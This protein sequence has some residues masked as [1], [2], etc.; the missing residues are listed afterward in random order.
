M[1]VVGSIQTAVL[2]NKS[3][4]WWLSRSCRG[5]NHMWENCSKTWGVLNR[6]NIRLCSSAPRPPRQLA[7]PSPTT[8]NSFCGCSS[9]PKNKWQVSSW[10]DKSKRQTEQLPSRL[11]K[12]LALLS[13]AKVSPNVSRDNLEGEKQ[14]RQKSTYGN[15]ALQKRFTLYTACKPG[16][17]K[18]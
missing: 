6:C 1:K 3:Y 12:L 8:Q 2:W 18:N 16:N 11:T 13:H 10:R 7:L 14:K 5:K 9:K 17:D 4:V 15:T